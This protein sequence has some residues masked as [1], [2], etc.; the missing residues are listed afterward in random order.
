ML[1]NES[2]DSGQTRGEHGSTPVVS[3]GVLLPDIQVGLEG[4]SSIDITLL[5]LRLDGQLMAFSIPPV[6]CS[7]QA[8]SLGEA[9]EDAFGVSILTF[10]MKAVAPVLTSF[11][12]Q[13]SECRA[14]NDAGQTLYWRLW[15]R[16]RLSSSIA[17][18]SDCIYR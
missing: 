11:V 8:K 3:D 12:H 16:G 9:A 7:V 6:S 18:F 4:T 14:K 10:S 5:L 15:H 13:A 17:D 1:N 2:G